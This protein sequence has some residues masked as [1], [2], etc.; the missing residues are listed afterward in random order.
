MVRPNLLECFFYY[1]MRQFGVREISRI[2][3]LNTKTVMNHLRTLT[4]RGIVL[5]RQNKGSYPYYEANRLSKR[6]TLL[7]SAWITEKIAAVGLIDYLEQ[8]IAP[9][10]IV[11]FGSAHKGTFLKDSDIDIFI[12]SREK[13]IDLSSFEKKLHH[14]IQPFFEE[15]LD[16]LTSGMRNNIINGSTVSGA[17]EL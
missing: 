12:Q 8:Q 10:A 1:P 4:R 16:N 5:R 17:L 11:L 3:R 15:H 9:K 6:Y 13:H 14:E 7:K 2:A